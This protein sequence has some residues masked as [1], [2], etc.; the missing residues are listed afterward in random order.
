MSETFE[1]FADEAWTHNNPSSLGRYWCFLGGVLGTSKDM[2]R[3][4]K[5][6]AK[7]KDNHGLKS[8]IKWKNINAENVDV[9]KELASCFFTFLNDK[10]KG[11]ENDHLIR[12]VY[13]GP[14]IDTSKIFSV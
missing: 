3:L 11:W 14:D 1:I 8:E 9:Y 2:D 4:H 6:L 7:V 5:I 12:G 13:Q 10:D